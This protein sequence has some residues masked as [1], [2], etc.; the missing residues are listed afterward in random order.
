MGIYCK[1][2]KNHTEYTHPKI[3]VL[4]SNN[5]RKVKSKCNKCLT[6]RT[7]FDKINEEYDLEEL[8]KQFSLLM[9]FIKEHKDLLREV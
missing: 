1:N 5:K 2:C 7:L 8:V 3:L 9:Y 6:D 4:I